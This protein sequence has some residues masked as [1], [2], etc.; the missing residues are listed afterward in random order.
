MRKLPLIG[1]AIFGAVVAAFIATRRLR[2]APDEGIASERPLETMTRDE[3]YELARAR[4]IPGRS[5]MKKAEL[6]AALDRP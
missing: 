6:V 3:L 1:L 5:R 4:N 2:A